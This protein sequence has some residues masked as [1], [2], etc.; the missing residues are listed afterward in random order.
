MAL[1]DVFDV[2]VRALV[3]PPLAVES[4][5]LADP[6]TPLLAALAD[7]AF[8]IEPVPKLLAVL[9]SITRM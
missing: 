3:I 7:E 9:L 1:A 2:V 5:M 8:K 6:T 4:V